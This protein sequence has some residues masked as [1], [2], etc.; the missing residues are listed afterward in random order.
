MV[1]CILNATEDSR[2][3]YIVISLVLGVDQDLNISYKA[4]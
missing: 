3:A 1:V 2:R 4:V